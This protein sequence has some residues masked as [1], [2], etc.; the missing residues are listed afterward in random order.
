VKAEKII[1]TIKRRSIE[2]MLKKG[3]RIDG[4][5]LNQMREI[6]IRTN[7]IERAEGS[8]LVKI[9]KT[10]VIAGVKLSI[11]SPFPDAPNKGVIIVN[12]EL[13][14]I[15]SPVF[16]PGPPGEEDVE[17]A[18]VVDRGIR[19]SNALNLDELIIIPGKKCWVVY[20]DIYAL[21]HD[22]NLIDACALAAVS[23]L[24]TAKKRKVEVE[25]DELKLL[26]ETEPLPMRDRP[27]F[28]TIGKIGESLIVDPSYEEELIIDSRIT[29]SITEDG[30]IA[31]IQKGEAG[32]LT[33]DEV[34]NASEVAFKIAED[35]RKLLPAL[36][37]GAS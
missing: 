27:V 30:R 11:G 13:I 10:M 7:F 14:P 22:G 17:I 12:T 37:K 29:F 8:A 24:L 21:N 19:S 34:L 2:A 23:A 4:R 6:S 18:R 31:A 16:E 26:E 28:V 36:P 1:P 33:Y 25:G 9:G 32:Y 5:K 15:A 20:V 3:E 35:V